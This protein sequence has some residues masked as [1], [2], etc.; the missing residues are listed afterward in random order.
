MRDYGSCLSIFPDI[1]LLL[2]STVQNYTLLLW[3]EQD[4]ISV[5][6]GFHNW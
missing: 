2:A 5:N 3:S 4:L 6:V 1:K